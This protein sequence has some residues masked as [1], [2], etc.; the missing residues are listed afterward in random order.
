[1][2]IL[3]Y[4][5]P[6]S[7]SSPVE[8]ALHELAVPHEKIRFDL[9]KNDQ[10]TPA[11]L[12]LNPNGKVPTLVVDGTPMFEALAIM[13]WLGD[14]YG[15]ARGVW[16]AADAPARLRALS[17]STWA[18]VQYGATVRMLNQATSERSPAELRNRAQGER[19]QQELQDLL[20]ILDRELAQ[21]R[22]MLGNEFGLV[23]LIVASVVAYGSHCGA[24]PKPHARVSDW[25]DRCMERPSLKA[26]WG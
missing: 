14:R 11:F 26:A 10:K 8:S 20:G 6:M 17:F 22:Y 7:S 2:L 25:L 12:K 5:A 16:P 15:V 23:D 18:Y 3:F 1:M 4:S 13:Q 9:S 19:A 21:Q 24:S